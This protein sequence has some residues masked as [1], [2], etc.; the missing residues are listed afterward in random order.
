MIRLLKDRFCRIA[1]TLF[2]HFGGDLGVG[3]SFQQSINFGDL[4]FGLAQLPGRG[5]H[6]HVEDF[7][8]TALKTDLHADDGV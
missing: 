7:G 3:T 1:P 8:S 5:R 4:R 2:V 6:R